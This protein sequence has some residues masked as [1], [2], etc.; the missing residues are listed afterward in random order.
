MYSPK[1]AIALAALV[2]LAACH[3]D[4]GP[5]GAGGAP[6][7]G[8]PSGGKPPASTAPAACNDLA[9]ARCERK[10]RCDPNGFFFYHQDM[11]ECLASEG[12]DCRYITTV[13]D[14]TRDSAWVA[15]CVQATAAGGCTEAYF[16]FADTDGCENRPGKRKT[17]QTCQDDVQCAS[18]LCGVTSSTARCGT[19]YPVIQEGGACGRGD[20]CVYPLTCLD[21][22]CVPWAQLGEPC[23]DKV[24]C[25]GGLTCRDGTCQATAK[26]GEP[27]QSLLDCQN[28]L[29]ECVGGVCV[30]P[31]I[32]QLGENCRGSFPGP[33]VY[34]AFGLDCADDLTCVPGPK[35]GESCNDPGACSGRAWCY[36]G[37]CE[38]PSAAW[39]PAS[40]EVKP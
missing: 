13:P 27:C 33:R 36:T 3:H 2:S 37:T 32:R 19:C 20:N 12:D 23:D 15:K 28:R 17:D 6:P 4:G 34:C 38:V 16:Q 18:L 31:E 25:T 30:G 7:D 1:G 10:M 26:D 24:T 29:S 11:A 40:G 39:C 8:A 14:S 21:G 5:G 22:T 9:R 35:L